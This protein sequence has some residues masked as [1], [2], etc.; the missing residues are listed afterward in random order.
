MQI[1]SDEVNIDPPYPCIGGIYNDEAIML[2]RRFYI[3]EN[4]RAPAPLVKKT[5]ELK[6]EIPP[7]AIAE[8]TL[9]SIDS[10]KQSVN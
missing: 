2:L 5:R 7:F 1:N 3:Q 6:S 9:A 8:M 4:E 10:K